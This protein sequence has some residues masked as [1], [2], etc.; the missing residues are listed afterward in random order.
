MFNKKEI[1]LFILREAFNFLKEDVNQELKDIE[2]RYSE[3]EK[4]YKE[5]IDSLN[6][7]V[8]ISKTQKDASNKSAN[9]PKITSPQK[10][11][12]TTNATQHDK[13]IK[14]YNEM[15][16]GLEQK[17]VDMKN[18]KAEDI[19]KVN[20]KASE[21]KS[22]VNISVNEN[23][24]TPNQ[25]KLQQQPQVAPQ[26]K[27]Q[28]QSQ[29]APQPEKSKDLIVRFDTNTPT[30]FTVKFTKRGFVVGGT[31]MSF[32]LIEQAINKRF[33]ITLKSGLILTP[34]KMQKILKYKE[35]I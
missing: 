7:K 34:V 6:T 35:R 17:I 10:Q 24:N 31:R 8:S 12:Y 20:E 22:E 26:P 14:S 11:Y 25:P 2:D 33:S 16:K 28:Q 27:I 1:D 18:E 5:E 29:V 9:A 15:K 13:N 30:P 19:R 3:K 4:K 21:Q 23:I 32:D